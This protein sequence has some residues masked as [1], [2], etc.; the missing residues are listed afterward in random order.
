MNLDQIIDDLLKS[1]D[2]SSEIDRRRA[3]IRCIEYADENIPFDEYNLFL[4]KTADK[5]GQSRLMRDLLSLKVKSNGREKIHIT[6]EDVDGCQ[7]IANPEG[8]LYLARAFRALST[9]KL[10]GEHIHLLYGEHPL[11]G[12]S[13]PAVLYMEDNAYFLPME[14][15]TAEEGT[16]WPV[17]KREIHP[18]D[19]AGMFISEYIPEQLMIT[20]NKVY[21]VLRWEWLTPGK[22][23]WKKEIREDSSRVVI[24][25]FI[26]D[27]GQEQEVGL[28]LDDELVGFVT[29]EEVKKLIR[30]YGI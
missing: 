15:G 1:V 8:C 12:E 16:E 9:S 25:T 3:Y 29:H 14:Q 27:D 28:D 18:K 6:F 5:L 17:V 30:P 7:I 13:Y 10:P 23:A 22:Q 2:M 11:K 26:R 21:P 20:V 4:A 24:F 19:I